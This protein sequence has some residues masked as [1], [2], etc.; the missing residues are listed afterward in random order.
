MFILD[1]DHVSLHQR[2]HTLI[3]SR[4]AETPDHLLFS[5]IITFQEQ[6]AGRLAVIKRARNPEKQARSYRRLRETQLYFCS[7]PLLLF[8]AT[9]QT[10]FWALKAK[11]I[12]ISTNDLM[13]ASIVLAYNGILLTRNMRDFRQVPDLQIEDWSQPSA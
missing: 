7:R 9:A 11:K 13:I 2:E 5:T 10:Q 3:A 8:D 1:T 4:I 6:I 12:R